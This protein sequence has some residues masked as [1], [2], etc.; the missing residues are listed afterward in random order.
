MAGPTGGDDDLAA[1]ATEAELEDALSRPTAGLLDSLRRIQGDTI[2]L[3]AGGKMG[4]S[5]ARMLRRAL[6]ELGRSERVIAVSRFSSGDAEAKLREAGVETE[7]RDLTDPA[8]VAALPDAPHVIFMAGQKFGTASAPSA[9]WALN[10]VTPGLVA[11]R[12]AASRIVAFST[13]NVYPL[14]P[15]VQRGAVETDAVGPVGEYAMSCLGRERVFEY[16][17]ERHRTPVAIVRLNYAIDLRYGV[18]ADIAGRVYRSEPVD[19]RMGH[20][21]VIWQGDAN[22]AAIRCLEHAASPPYILNVTGRETV[23]VRTLATKF[24][25][26]FRRT[27]VIVGSEAHDALLSNATRAA[28]LFG[29]PSVSLDQMIA[30]VAQW[31]RTGGPMLGKPTRFETRDGRF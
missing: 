20:V 27:P 2:V 30:W 28:Q 24:G 11:Q 17:S 31:V 15:V 8:A 23:A 16:F 18:L 12:Y 13:G 9:T 25:E 14:S 10:T 21:N 3:G 7:R 26:R 6:D 22:A 5:L 19:V 4:P 1:P 29:V